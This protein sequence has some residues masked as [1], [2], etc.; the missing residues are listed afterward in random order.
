M[1]YTEN[2]FFV[3]LI[4]E[5]LTLYVVSQWLTKSFYG[6]FLLLFRARP[7][8][9][10]AVTLLLFPG[11]VVHE[12]SHLFTAEILGVKTG[13]LELAPESIRQEDVR[14]GSVAI[15]Q[16]DPLRRSAIGLAPLGSGLLA[17]AALSWWL[18]KIWNDLQPVLQSGKLFS[19]PPLYVLCVIF[20]LLFSVS[21]A[22]FSSSQD[23][24][25]C[26]PLVIVL[27][28]LVTGAYGLGFR[29]FLTGQ[30]LDITNRILQSLVQSLGLVLAVNAILLLA[31]RILVLLAGKITHQRLV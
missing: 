21:N 14:I 20:Y 2:M 19:S 17:L 18:P 6:F 8:A 27:V 5:L 7:V 28:I 4:I 13:K 29:F 15:A 12:L 24:K 16:T 10:S 26:L 3:I 11:T 30:V 1:V 23:L 22:M 31:T 25:G 9:V